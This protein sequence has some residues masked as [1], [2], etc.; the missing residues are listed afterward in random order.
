MKRYTGTAK[1]E[2][3][4][5]NWLKLNYTM[6]FTREDNDHPTKAGWYEAVALRG[7]PVLPQ[8]D[9][10]GN[11][12]YY[13]DLTSWADGGQTRLKLIISIIS[14]GLLLSQ[15][16]IGRPLLISIIASRIITIIVGLCL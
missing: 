12:L 5:T 11:R 2:S 7:W 13:S 3:Q 10:N 6:R 14:W 1:I 4:L 9:W 8:Y 15:S 16:R